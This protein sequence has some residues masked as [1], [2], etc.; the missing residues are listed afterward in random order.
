M[1]V[2][3]EKN[4][5][6][7]DKEQKPSD[8]ATDAALPFLPHPLVSTP[9]GIPD[10]EKTARPQPHTPTLPTVSSYKHTASAQRERNQT[11]GP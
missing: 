1:K 8:G 10:Q 4:Q 6:K 5:K 3:C 2:W 11:N 9:K 7:T